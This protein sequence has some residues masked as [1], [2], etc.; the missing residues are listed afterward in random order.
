MNVWRAAV[1]FPFGLACGAQ[2][3]ATDAGGPDGGLDGQVAADGAIADS[4]ND[5][6]DGSACI[7]PKLQALG[8]INT[9][10]SLLLLDVDDIAAY[11]SNGLN[12][13]WRC[14]LDAS[15]CQIIS[16]YSGPTEGTGSLT[17]GPTAV[18]WLA[19]QKSPPHAYYT[20]WRAPKTGGTA[21]VLTTY[22]DSRIQDIAFIGSSL[23]FQVT[24]N[25]TD[26]EV[27]ELASADVGATPLVN[28]TVATNVQQPTVFASD[29]L[30]INNIGGG[31]Q[32]T[33]TASLSNP[34][35]TFMKWNVTPQSIATIESA[36]PA[37]VVDPHSSAL[38]QTEK[39]G[40]LVFGYA[41][42]DGGNPAVTGCF[43]TIAT[44]GSA[45]SSS[46]VA[47]G[48]LPNNAAW[49]VLGTI[50]NDP[51]IQTSICLA[52]LGPGLTH[53][54]QT[55]PVAAYAMEPLWNLNAVLIRGGYVYYIPSD[56]SATRTLKR[57]VVQ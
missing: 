37:F 49:N 18:F 50:G 24:L 8:S 30:L 32:P 7:A 3:P 56:T 38:L 31:P 29:G 27:H 42:T 40:V 25:S 5:T 44:L 16:S 13:V 20:I 52:G 11:L 26:T 45:G 23:Y 41:T 2:S 46:C 15:G 4:G 47:Q 48:L 10:N 57:F 6:A 53:W 34:N 19:V 51:V 22:T 17:I 33:W 14:P 1:L 12:T 35:S 36:K 9:T 21:T 55:G 54:S 39:G 43:E 28:D